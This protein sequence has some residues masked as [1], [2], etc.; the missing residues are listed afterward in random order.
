[1]IFPM[2]AALTMA[3]IP[4]PI[5]HLSGNQ[6]QV[7]F[8]IRHTTPGE[9][10]SFSVNGEKRYW[11]RGDSSLSVPT[12]IN[13]SETILSTLAALPASGRFSPRVM[14][15]MQAYGGGGCDRSGHCTGDLAVRSTIP[16][17]RCIILYKG[18]H[19]DGKKLIIDSSAQWDNTDTRFNVPDPVLD[20][21]VDCA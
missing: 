5:C 18:G 1:M 20:I 4:G 12:C 11:I 2:L 9:D 3:A 6:R 7:N 15:R 17:E 21:E 16:S 10:L 14:W 13:A 8:R 19:Y